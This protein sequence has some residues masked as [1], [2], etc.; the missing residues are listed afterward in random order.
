MTHL[1]L[2]PLK[3]SDGRAQLQN[4]CDTKRFII[5]ARDSSHIKTSQGV[6][7]RTFYANVRRPPGPGP[8]AA[9]ARDQP[10]TKSLNF[11]E[12][13]S[14]SGLQGSGRRARPEEG[15]VPSGRPAPSSLR[16][17]GRFEQPECVSAQRRRVGRLSP[18]PHSTQVAGLCRPSSVSPAAPDGHAG[19]VFFLLRQRRKLR[20][21]ESQHRS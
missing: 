13:N 2:V 17:G 9:T 16:G 10:E 12:P 18:A 11:D 5:S 6:N 8:E 7:C 20:D 15:A 14:K 21:S 1:V 3:R 19:N 4:P